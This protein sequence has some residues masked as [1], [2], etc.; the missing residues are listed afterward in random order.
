MYPPHHL[1]GYELV[2]RSAMAHLRAQGHEVRV[3][4]TDF[5]TR[6]SAP[7]DAGTYRELRW[8]WRDHDWPSISWPARVELERHNHAVLERHMAELRP[9]VVS[10]WAMGGMS[11]SLLER[12]RRAG[13]PAVAF[14]HDDW[15]SY[16]PRV[17]RWTR[18]FARHRRAAALAERATGVPA[19]VELEHAA[20][21]VFVSETTRERARATGLELVDSGIAHS[22]IDPSFLDPR[23]VTPWAWRLLYVGRVDERKGVGDAI[24]ALERLP[25]EATLTIAGSGEAGLEKQLTDMAVKLGVADRVRWLGMRARAELPGVYEAADVVLFPVRWEEPW[26][27]VPLEAMA[28]GR[29]VIATGRGGSGEYLRDGENALIVPA[30]DPAAMADAVRRLADDPEL[31]GRLRTGGSGTAATHTET[32]F[33]AA[34]LDALTVASSHR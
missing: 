2:W 10:W 6:T 34:A 11:L 30:H 22:G 23:P 28:L 25:P 17:D 20:R 31:A 14:V 26:G 29:P 8:Y 16:G 1:G 4:T 18:A 33:N 9:D 7:E 24:A 19:R 32:I 3:L 21:F 13:P 12:V 5:S 15:L 27:L